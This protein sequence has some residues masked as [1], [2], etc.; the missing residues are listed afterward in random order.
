MKTVALFIAAI[1]LAGCTVMDSRYS[2]LPRAGSFYT[3]SLKLAYAGPVKPLS[4][5][6][7]ISFSRPMYVVSVNGDYKWSKQNYFRKGLQ[8]VGVSQVHFLPGTYDLEFC[9]FYTDPREKGRCITTVKRKVDLQAGSMTF[10]KLVT[11]GR[12]GWT[13]DQLD[14]LQDKEKVEEEFKEMLQF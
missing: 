12:D 14:M 11:V 10:F 3:K 5:V 4:D 7:V 2:D 13:V 6:G 8:S 9:F 1:L